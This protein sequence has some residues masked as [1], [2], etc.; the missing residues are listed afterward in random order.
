MTVAIGNDV[1]TASDHGDAHAPVGGWIDGG[2]HTL[3]CA[4]VNA[5]LFVATFTV[6]GIG[7]F[8]HEASVKLRD[9]TGGGGGC[10]T[11]GLRFLFAIFCLLND[12]EVPPNG[13]PV[14]HAHEQV[15]AAGITFCDWLAHACS[16]NSTENAARACCGTTALPKAL[17]A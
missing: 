5:A 11:G 7:V 12:H 16:S 14:H 10:T 4:V 3:A 1:S 13:A 2:S 6:D 15:S 8:H 17:R 9:L